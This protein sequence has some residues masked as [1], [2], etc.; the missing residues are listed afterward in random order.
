MLMNNINLYNN[1]NVER[2]AALAALGSTAIWMPRL[3]DA[4]KVEITG[5][6]NCG[7]EGSL[8]ALAGA[9]NNLLNILQVLTSGVTESIIEMVM[10]GMVNQFDQTHIPDTPQP[11]W[12]TSDAKLAADLVYN[13]KVMILYNYLAF[14]ALS[15]IWTLLRGYTHNSFVFYAQMTFYAR[16]ILSY[17]QSLLTVPFVHVSRSVPRKGFLEALCVAIVLSF[18]I[19]ILTGKKNREN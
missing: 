16:C 5:L 11:D 1:R 14:M 6:M 15:P 8:T 7:E 10:P 2:I 4:L 19:C 12:C 17:N 3:I 13:A 18:A 9:H